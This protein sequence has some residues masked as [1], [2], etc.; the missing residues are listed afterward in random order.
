MTPIVLC[1]GVGSQLTGIAAGTFGGR[2]P[3]TVAGRSAVFR[4][5]G[6]ARCVRPWPPPASVIEI[7]I[8]ILG[9]PATP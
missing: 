3:R 5:V 2:I 9:P 6:V 1:R 4:S 8:E 7:R